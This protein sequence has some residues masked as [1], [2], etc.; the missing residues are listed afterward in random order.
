MNEI[1]KSLTAQPLMCAG[2]LLIFG[3]LGA[4][5]LIQVDPSLAKAGIISGFGLIIASLYRNRS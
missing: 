4:T 3:S 2:L 5:E 1:L